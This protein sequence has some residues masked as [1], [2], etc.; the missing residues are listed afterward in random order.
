MVVQLTENGIHNMIRV[1][2]GRIEVF[3]EW[4]LETTKLSC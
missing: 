4:Y 3:S 2:H 1:S